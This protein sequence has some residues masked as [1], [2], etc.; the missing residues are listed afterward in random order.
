[1]EKN[2]ELKQLEKDLRHIEARYDSMTKDVLENL[3]A[4]NK[5]PLLNFAENAEFG[6]SKALNWAYKLGIKVGKGI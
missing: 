5:L 4:E 3:G 2:N 1:M 6:I